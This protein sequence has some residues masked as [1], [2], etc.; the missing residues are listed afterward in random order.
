[1]PHVRH[2]RKQRG[3]KK[4]QQR[5]GADDCDAV[6]KIRL[7][8]VGCVDWFSPE[9]HAAMATIDPAYRIQLQRRVLMAVIE[10]EKK[11]LHDGQNPGIVDDMMMDYFEAATWPEFVHDYVLDYFTR[12]GMSRKAIRDMI[13]HLKGTRPPYAP[14]DEVPPQQ[15]NQ[16]Q[17][18]QMYFAF[19]AQQAHDNPPQPQHQPHPG[20]G[21][22]LPP[23]LG[24][25]TSQS[26]IVHNL[27][28]SDTLDDVQ[29]PPADA[30][31][32][33]Q[34]LAWIRAA[35]LAGDGDPVSMETWDDMTVDQLRN[36]VRT[37]EGRVYTTESLEGIINA[38]VEAKQEPRD[39]LSRSR[40]TRK[41]FRALRDVKLRA[42][43]AYRLPTRIQQRP[44]L[45]MRLI[46]QATNDGFYEM[47]LVDDR[48]DPKQV[49]HHLGFVPGTL[50]AVHTGSADYSSGTLLALLQAAWE[51]GKFLGSYNKPFPCCRFHLRKG[52]GWWTSPGSTPVNRLKAMIDEIRANTT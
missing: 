10:W 9:G 2:T 29:I 33:E 14:L 43:P 1:M 4:R 32:K 7:P 51:N 5:G 38:A 31:T 48:T 39:P 13:K 17:L 23:L 26:P 44:P 20:V 34:L 22:G 36:T 21:V 19:L 52:K 41:N 37:K 15:L 8:G 50:D 3:H 24:P 25:L 49:I 47:A 18:M 42:D 28:F 27:E 16:E 40:L 30:E 35:H 45:Y 46:I 6:G 11:L 12:S